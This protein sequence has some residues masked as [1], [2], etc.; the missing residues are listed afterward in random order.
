MPR[1]NTIRS[2]LRLCDYYEHVGLLEPVTQ[3]WIEGKVIGFRYDSSDS[4][5]V[6]LTNGDLIHVPSSDTVFLRKVSRRVNSPTSATCAAN[7]TCC[8]AKVVRLIDRREK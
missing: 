6:Q 1:D 5:V 4:F 8:D 2:N 7:E 3:T